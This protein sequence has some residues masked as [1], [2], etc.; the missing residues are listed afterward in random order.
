LFNR[1]R[2]RGQRADV[3]QYLDE[4]GVAL[5]QVEKADTAQGRRK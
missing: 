3:E 2:V 1:W 4:Y 5:K